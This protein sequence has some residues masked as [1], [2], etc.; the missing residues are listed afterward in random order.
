MTQQVGV[1]YGDYI[2]SVLHLNGLRELQVS[3]RSFDEQALGR[4]DKMTKLGNLNLRDGATDGAALA[5]M[6]W[7]EQLYGL[8]VESV[9]DVTLLLNRL[10]HSR[11]IRTLSIEKTKFAKQD[12]ANIASM[13]G[14]T[15][16]SLRGSNITNADLEELTRLQGL[17]ELDISQCSQLDKHCIETIKKFKK[18]TKLTAPHQLEQ[19]DGAAPA[20]DYENSSLSRNLTKVLPGVEIM[21]R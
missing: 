13:K 7:L 11:K 6:K 4:L 1:G 20:A 9:T 15:V 5:R 3:G 12:F 16:L 19:Q 18:L 8:H 17:A 2:A 10:V 14:L 21:L